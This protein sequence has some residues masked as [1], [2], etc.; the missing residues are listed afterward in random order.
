[1][2]KT[3]RFKIEYL[4]AA[5]KKHL[6]LITGIV[7]LSLGVIAFYQPIYRLAKSTSSTTNRIGQSGLF[8]TK[9]LPEDIVRLIS[10]GLTQPQANDRPTDSP[11]VVSWT[12]EN[13]NKDYLFDLNPNAYWHNGRR[14][15]A[16]DVNYDIAGL[17]I[18]PLSAN[19]LKIS[20]ERPFSPLLSL[21]ETPLLDKNLQG[22]GP[23]RVDSIEY[24]D[25]YIKNLHLNPIDKTLPKLFYRFYLNE[26][27]LVSAYKMGEIDTIKDISSTSDLNQWPKTKISP[28]SLEN[29]RYLALFFNT[30]KLNNKQLRQAL[31]YATP[32]PKDKTE[33]C[34][35]PIS[36]LSWAYNSSVKEYNQNATRAK[37]LFDKNKID[38][39][40][41]HLNNRK[42]LSTAEEIKSA[43]ES[44]L[45]IKTSIVLENQIDT[46]D[47][48]VIL[49]FGS[50]L[51]DPDQYAFWHSTQTATNVTKFANS[52]I[53][54][55]LEDGRLTLD[56]QERKKIYFDF[57]RYLLEESPA[58][59]ISYPTTYT[60][61]RVQ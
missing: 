28:Q 16:Y 32:K 8:T 55:L 53:D 29:N 48:D 1:M 52:R 45:N 38:S 40:S 5:V 36:P 56:Q 2:L 33:R 31:A 12:T 18:Q 34:L 6:T 7:I 37:E 49:A 3:L 9:N 22:L 26:D 54:K 10:F 11:L 15:S 20:L 14:F 17:T 42:L 41:I 51:H 46:N 39:I 44:I 60:V 27:D 19:K 4:L 61:T 58:I 13:D 57:Q 59:F 43:W 35:G 24:Q 50:I 47:F 21:L 25:G 23:Y 30:Q